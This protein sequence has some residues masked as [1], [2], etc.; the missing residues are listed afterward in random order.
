VITTIR[1]AGLSCSH[2]TFC[3]D[4]VVGSQSNESASEYRRSRAAFLY[5]ASSFAPEL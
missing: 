1:S 2:E 3:I 4:G 5:C